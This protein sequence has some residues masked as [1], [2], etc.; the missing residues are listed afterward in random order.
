MS[1]T[2]TNLLHRLRRLSAPP[3][4]DPDA[5][6]LRRF[7]CRGDPDAF[8]ELLARHG[9]LVWNACRRV[10]PDP[11]DAEDA[12]QATFLVLARRAGSVRRPE[13]LAGWLYGVAHRVARD[14]RRRQRRRP[15]TGCVELPEPKDPRPDPL[16]GL[17][18]RDLLAVL[19]EEVRRLPAAHRLPVVLCCLEGLSQ[20]EAAR[21]LGWTAGAVK[22][23]LE[24]GRKRLHER[25]VRRGL[26][27]GAALGVVEAARGAGGAPAPLI[28]S[29]VR[30]VGAAA[31]GGVPPGVAAL[32]KGV[33]RTMFLAKLK[34]AAVVLSVVAL[35]GGAALLA[36][37]ARPGEAKGER[38]EGPRAKEESKKEGAPAEPSDGGKGEA[39]L[40]AATLAKIRKLQ[41]ERRNALKK[42]VEAWEQEFRAGRRTLADVVKTSRQLLDAELELATTARQRIKAHAEHLRLMKEADKVTAAG[43]AAGQVRASDYFRAR[44]ARLKAEINWLKAGGKDETGKDRKR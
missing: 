17:M 25:L 37:A 43:Y 21:R 19:E 15:W 34:V 23:R 14:A 5:E 9:P 44:A 26:S 27:L 24:R 18:A 32:T 11:H 39:K 13:S 8:A 35:A 10:L 28:D 1:P 36:H 33:L 16:A 12:F 31:G 40:G 41:L 20:E 2:L 7:A 3:G 22:G 42:A 6:L 29:T 4:A 30:L 38:R